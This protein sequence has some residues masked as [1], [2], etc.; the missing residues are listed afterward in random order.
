MDA[1]PAEGLRRVHPPRGK[2]GCTAVRRMLGSPTPRTG[3]AWLNSAIIWR[4]WI[5]L[6]I[7]SSSPGAE[8]LIPPCRSQLGLV[9]EG[10]TTP[11]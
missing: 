7:S 11:A 9:A 1:P 4:R 5:A 3:G 8:Q 10:G 2:A 6:M